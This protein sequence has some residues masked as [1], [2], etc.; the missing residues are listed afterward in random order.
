ME[1]NYKLI[2]ND[3]ETKIKIWNEIIFPQYFYVE[4]I[5]YDW[6]GDLITYKKGDYW[7]SLNEEE[8]KEYLLT[9]YGKRYDNLIEYAIYNKDE[10][11]GWLCYV[12]QDKVSI[13]KYVI[14][15][16]EHQNK[17]LGKKIMKFYFDL[18]KQ[19]D[20][21]EIKL[22]FNYFTK[23]LKEF[24]LK[25]G[26]KGIKEPSGSHLSVSKKIRKSNKK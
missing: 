22:S 8:K 15:K 21:K 26:F 11:I 17:G 16:E 19:D 24:Y 7:E 23:G 1:L 5:Y 25:L 20:I 2:E 13:L 6:Y 12:I 14:I 4:D 3:N 18:I 9:K 10:L